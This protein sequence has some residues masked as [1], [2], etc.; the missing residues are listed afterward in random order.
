M[1]KFHESIA[2]ETKNLN[3]SIGVIVF[4]PSLL[5][6]AE[7]IIKGTG[8]SAE[9]II[10]LYD[11]KRITYIPRGVYLTS[12]NNVKGLEFSKVYVLGLNLESINSFYAAKKAFVAVTRAMNELEIFWI[13]PQYI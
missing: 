6:K 8:L 11:K 5:N 9:S 7:E 10:V 3:K 4:D 12:F 1:E 13:K 2:Q